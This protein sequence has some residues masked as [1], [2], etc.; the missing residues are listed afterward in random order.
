MGIDEVGIDKVGIDKVG[1]TPD[2][3]RSEVQLTTELACKL[4]CHRKCWSTFQWQV[5]KNVCYTQSSNHMFARSKQFIQLEM[6]ISQYIH[7]HIH[8]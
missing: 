4:I 7:I 6:E 8:T 1:I 3:K 2:N 5:V